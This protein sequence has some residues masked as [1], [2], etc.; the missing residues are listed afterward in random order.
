MPLDYKLKNGDI[1]EIVTTKGEHGPSRDWL[2]VVRTSHAR[3][4][5][6]QWFKRQER[7]ENIAHGRESIDREL[8][9]LARTI[10][11]AVGQDRMLEIAR[12]YKLR[13]PRRLLRGGRL[14][15]G[16]ARSRS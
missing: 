7:D 9:R 15:R 14:R 1:V 8:R 4:K 16:R 2:N 5:I 10:M 3:E 12:V 6:R 11:G 13:D